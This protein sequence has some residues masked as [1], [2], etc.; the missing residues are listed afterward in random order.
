MVEEHGRISRI[1]KK[2]RLYG[3]TRLEQ[4]Y[5]RKIDLGGI[6]G[7]LIVIKQNMLV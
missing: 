7:K 5:K 4:Q 6:S 3:M 2:R 1:R